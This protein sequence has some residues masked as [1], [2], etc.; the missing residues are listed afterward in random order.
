MDECVWNLI[1]YCADNG[2]DILAK[3]IDYLVITTMA[4]DDVNK[5]LSYFLFLSKNKEN[6]RNDSI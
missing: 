4:L 5:F 3:D 6:S 1:K 2:Q